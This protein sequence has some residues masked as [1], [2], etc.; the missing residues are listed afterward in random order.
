MASRQ[1]SGQRFEAA[2]LPELQFGGLDDGSPRALLHSRL[3][4]PA[5][6]EIVT[7]LVRAARGNPLALLER[8]VSL[9]D[10][11]LDGTDPI[12]GPLRAK[13]AA[14][15]DHGAVGARRGIPSV[16][17]GSPPPRPGPRLM[18]WLLWVAVPAHRDRT[19]DLERDL[20][21]LK[22]LAE[23]SPVPGNHRLRH[24]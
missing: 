24:P 8:P 9:T 20:E 15:L 18:E 5:A 17:G 23:K 10:R 6:D 14:L 1:R 21:R 11:Q 2:G 13:G 7:M 16:R 12:A 4:R 3:K 19:P 22:Q